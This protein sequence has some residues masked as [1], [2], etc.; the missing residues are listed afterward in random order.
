MSNLRQS[1]PIVHSGDRV[2]DGQPP[3]IR[4]FAARLMGSHVSVRSRSGKW[5]KDR[6]PFQDGLPLWVILEGPSLRV[7]PHED[8]EK[9]PPH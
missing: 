5:H 8:P 4:E 9:P 1:S 7:E 6:Y 3:V 2:E